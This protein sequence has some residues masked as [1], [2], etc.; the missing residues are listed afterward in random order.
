MKTTKNSRNLL[1]KIVKIPERSLSCENSLR[2]TYF[3]IRFQIEIHLQEM[4]V[5][6]R[7]VARDSGDFRVA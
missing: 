3:E 5:N 1:K 6:K 7:F 4:Q 2:A